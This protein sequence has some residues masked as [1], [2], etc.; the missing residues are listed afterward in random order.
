MS[1]ARQLAEEYMENFEAWEKEAKAERLK[2]VNWDLINKKCT[3]KQIEA[4][5]LFVE[6]RLYEGAASIAEMSILDFVNL[7]DELGVSRG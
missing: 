2:S 4:I 6:Y 5:K 1:N 3:K 7:L